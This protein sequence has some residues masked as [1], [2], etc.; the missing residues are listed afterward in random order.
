MPASISLFLSVVIDIVARDG[1]LR[2]QKGFRLIWVDGLVVL[3]GL[4]SRA[5]WVWAVG[6]KA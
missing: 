2:V 3:K 4:E 5:S 1:R 6:F